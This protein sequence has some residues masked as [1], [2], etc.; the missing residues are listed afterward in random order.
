MT[1]LATGTLRQ[2]GERKMVLAG[3]TMLMVEV[4]L[5]LGL[6]YG[7]IALALLA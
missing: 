6:V 7:P 1:M 2:T 3:R 5:N 4:M